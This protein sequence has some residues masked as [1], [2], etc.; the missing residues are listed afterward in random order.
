MPLTEYVFGKGYG[1]WLSLSLAFEMS[2]SPRGWLTEF[3]LVVDSQYHGSCHVCNF[4]RKGL[5]DVDEQRALG[6]GAVIA[7]V[8]APPILTFA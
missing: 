5:R 4:I 1:R 8:V 7:A 2:R 6:H 3:P